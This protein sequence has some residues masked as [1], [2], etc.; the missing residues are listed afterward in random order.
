VDNSIGGG[1]VV[2]AAAA[3]AV[4]LAV[5]VALLVGVLGRITCGKGCDD[6]VVATS[7]AG[8]GAMVDVLPTAGASVNNTGGSG[9]VG[10]IAAAGAATLA[11]GQVGHGDRVGAGSMDGQYE[12]YDEAPP[13]DDTVGGDQRWM[14]L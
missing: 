5:M 1:D 4:G 3:T 13:D 7:E 10:I 11:L 2:V 6:G 8:N 12:A 14:V 9:I